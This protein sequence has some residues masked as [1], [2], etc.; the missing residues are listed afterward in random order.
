MVF[1]QMLYSVTDVLREGRQLIHPTEPKKKK[2]EQP[3]PAAILFVYSADDAGGKV[4]DGL[5]HELTREEGGR[6]G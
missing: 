6:C 2:D 5:S 1:A 3:P 4:S